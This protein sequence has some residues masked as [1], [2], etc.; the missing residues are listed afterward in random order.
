MTAFQDCTR[1][2]LVLLNQRDPGSPL[3]PSFVPDDF[4]NAFGDET[5]HRLRRDAHRP[6]HRRELDGGL[7]PAS[8][9][10]PCRLTA[11]RFNM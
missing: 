7:A 10:L 1:I 6:H 11:G 5:P 9:R 3:L 4:A 8:G 2:P